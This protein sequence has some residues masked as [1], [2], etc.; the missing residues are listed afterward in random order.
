ML[1]KGRSALQA[2]Y[3][4]QMRFRLYDIF[5][6]RSKDIDNLLKQ[7]LFQPCRYFHIGYRLLK[8]LARFGKRYYLFPPVAQLV[9]QAP[10]K[11]KVR[12]FDPSRADM[13]A[14][15]QQCIELRKQDH[16]LPEIV[17][18]TGRPKGSIYFHVRGIPLSEE[19]RK[20]ISATNAKRALRIA[21]SRKGVSSRSFIRFFH[22]DKNLVLLVAHLLFDGEISSRTCAYN[23]RS[24]T[25]ISRV[26]GLMRRLYVYEP[27]RREN[28]QTG[29]HRISYYNVALAA[30]MREKADALVREIVS[31]PRSYQCAFLRAFF[32]DEGCM[33]FRP[34]RNLRRVR[35]YQKDTSIL[36]L[37][38]MLLKNFGISAI[39][40][41]K[42]EVVIRGREDLSRFQKE[43][44]FSEGVRING[45]RSNSIW[46]ESLENQDQF[47]DR[48]HAPSSTF[49]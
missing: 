45:N 49:R 22:W 26:E 21:G 30:F 14:F 44:N 4:L 1:C 34:K 13:N 24:L 39:V 11:G 43:I 31:L 28:V 47:E 5:S 48:E 10:F 36:I 40:Q 33:D 42:N 41:G 8:Y 32:D 27:K 16:T 18:I 17:A 7:C 9:E 6:L 25:L 35:G 37:V 15:K 46:K 38:R 2:Q 19:K 23:N 12:R 3:I 29:V 20:E